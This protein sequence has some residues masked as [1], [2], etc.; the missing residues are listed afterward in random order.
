MVDKQVK[1]VIYR[2]RA[3]W[4][5]L[6]PRRRMAQSV[7]GVDLPAVHLTSTGAATSRTPVRSIHSHRV[8]MGEQTNR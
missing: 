5:R 8:E 1:S 3:Y 7:I 6:P 2:G 4:T